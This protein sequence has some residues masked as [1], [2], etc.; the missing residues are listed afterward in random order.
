MA[1]ALVTAQPVVAR[2]GFV[3]ATTAD[4]Q[5]TQVAPGHV[6]LVAQI[7]SPRPFDEVVP[8]WSAQAPAGSRIEFYLHPDAP[9][10]GRY[11]L[12]VWSGQPTR[13]SVKDQKDAAGSVDTDTLTL[14][15]TT[16]KV[17]VEIDLYGSESAHPRL[18]AFH[19]VLVDTKTK[20]RARKPLKSAWGKTLEPPRRAQ[21]SYPNGDGACSPTSV[22]MILGYWSKQL[23]KPELDHDVPEV[24]KGVYDVAW[25]GTGNWPFNMAYAASQPGLTAY[26]SR[27]RDVRDLEEW[28]AAGVPVAT[29]VSYPLLRGEPRKPNDGHLVVL[30][31]FTHDGD[32]VFNDPGRNA[33]RMT[34]K[35]ADFE[36]AWAVSRNTVYLV[37][38]KHWHVPS[39]P[40]PWEH[41]KR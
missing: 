21:M 40:G 28:V 32:P 8:S 11:C 3:S 19:L 5:S 23:K 1:L 34:Y 41:A 2:D 39:G 12:G 30:T 29:S 17:T 14:T 4:F 25:S 20:T 31:G 35:R 18:D 33:V 22:S 37:Y 15:S 6:R 7:E 24:Q 13:T 27:F 38:P 36:R 9:G 16:K 26:V 10:A